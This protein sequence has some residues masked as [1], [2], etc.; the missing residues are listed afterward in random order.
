MRVY[1]HV[2]MSCEEFQAFVSL[3]R[4]SETC[5]AT[6]YL[7]PLLAGWLSG[8]SGIECTAANYDHFL[9]AV[10]LIIDAILSGRLSLDYHGPHA[11]PYRR[12]LAGLHDPNVG[13]NVLSRMGFDYIV[14]QTEKGRG[15][16]VS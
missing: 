3:W 6:V 8:G 5:A 15:S 16:E 11:E 13:G 10:V 7:E 4:P 1:S 9:Q 2:E 12:F 14:R